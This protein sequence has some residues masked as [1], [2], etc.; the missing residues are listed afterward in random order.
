MTHANTVSPDQIVEALGKS[1]RFPAGSKPFSVF[2]PVIGHTVT[3][4]GEAQLDQPVGIAGLCGA[5]GRYVNWLAVNQ[6]FLD[7]IDDEAPLVADLYSGLGDQ[8]EMLADDPALIL[9]TTGGDE[10]AALESE[11]LGLNDA[12]KELLRKGELTYGKLLLTSPE[13]FI[14]R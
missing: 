7:S 9:Q 2:A 14:P 3:A 5:V 11:Q 1:P 4:V 12:A 8:L 13:V 10:T 6:D